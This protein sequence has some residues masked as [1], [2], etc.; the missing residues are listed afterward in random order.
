MN[1]GKSSY[2]TTCLCFDLNNRDERTCYDFFKRCGR[3]WKPFLVTVLEARFPN[4]YEKLIIDGELEIL[5]KKYARKF[6]REKGA[7]PIFLGWHSNEYELDSRT[8]YLLNAQ[9]QQGAKDFIVFILKDTLPF[10]FGNVSTVSAISNDENVK[11]DQLPKDNEEYE[12]DDQ[13]STDD[14]E[15]EIEDRTL[16]QFDDDFDDDYE[17][18]PAN[19]ISSKK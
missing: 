7:N 19:Y 18:I 8:D 1:K 17:I 5:I 12:G 15:Y 16:D 9:L 14:D 10:I 3:R 13:T 4:Y 11:D 2:P 6:T